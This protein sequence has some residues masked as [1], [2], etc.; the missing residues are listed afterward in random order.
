LI[1]CAALRI[2]VQMAAMPPY[3]GLD[4]SWHV[5]R[6]AFVRAE[7]RQ[8][9]ISEA[10]IPPYVGAS[11]NARPG[12]MPSFGDNGKRWPEIVRERPVLVDAPMI[13][14]PY[15][16]PNYEAQQPSF[17][18]AIAARLV[19]QRSAI[20]ELRCWRALSLFF[21]LICVVATAEIGRHWLGNLGILAGALLIA[22]PTWLTLVM[23]AS[24]DAMACALIAVGFAI[25]I[26]SCGGG[27]SARRGRAGEAS[28]PRR[29]RGG[30]TSTGSNVAPA[31]SRRIAEPLVWAAACATKLYAWPM[32]LPLAFLLWRQRAGRARAIVVTLACAIVIITT[33]ADLQ[34]RTRNPLGD[35]GFDNPNAVAAPQPIDVKTMVKTTIATMVWTSGQHVDALTL[36][37]MAVYVLPL[38]VAVA[39]SRGRAVSWRLATPR[40]RDLATIAILSFALAQLI[41]AAAFVRQARAAGLSLPVG[42]KEGWYWYALAPLLIPLLL[43]VRFAAWWLVAWDV[44]I[45]D[46]QLFHDYAGSASPLHPSLLFRWGPLHWPFTAHLAGIGVGPFATHVAAMR[47]AQL[48]LFFVLESF[49]HDRR[50]FHDRVAE[51]PPAG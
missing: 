37:G 43:R 40:P 22:L 1:L 13:V 30:A 15:E 51:P 23:R 44:V 46:A 48:V 6:L 11:I 2:F 12:A 41:N 5:A 47:L 27:L 18:Y 34:R 8:P 42:G 19:P 20:F 50:A 49:L 21:A 36:L 39:R 31:L 32:L 25:S 9:T 3:A 17:Y 7:G 4:E 16:S 33:G 29:L 35:F 24:N 38:L 14:K 45:N 10:S 28:M 26:S